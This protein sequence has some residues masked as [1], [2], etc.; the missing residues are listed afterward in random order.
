MNFLKHLYHSLWDLDWLEQMKNKPRQSWGYFFLFMLVLVILT[1]IPFFIKVPEIVDKAQVLL[2]KE[3][4]EFKATFQDGDLHVTELPQPYIMEKEIPDEEKEKILIYIDTSTTEPL[5]AKELGQTRSTGSI[6]LVTRDRFEM[7]DA[8]EGTF[9]V[10]T[11]DD[12]PNVSFTKQDIAG[13][14]ASKGKT[15]LS[16]IFIFMALMLY[17]FGTA[18]KLL[19]IVIWAAILSLVVRIAKKEG[20]DFRGIFR[21]G[22]STIILP[23]FVLLIAGYIAYKPPIIFT[24][25]FLVLTCSV[26]FREKDK[27]GIPDKKDIK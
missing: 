19:Y 21:L 13:L 20:W 3:V 16:S 2:D 25:I 15:A 6:F 22:L 18:W 10:E 1:F 8:E 5:S 26:I 4:P 17:F 23:S 9:E 14:V 11:F 24:I 7:Y 12:I 27:A